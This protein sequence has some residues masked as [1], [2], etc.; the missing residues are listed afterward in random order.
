[1]PATCWAR[2]PSISVAAAG[3]CASGDAVYGNPNAGVLF[4][5]SCTVGLL[6]SVKP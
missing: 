3:V 6:C 5:T 1:M 4:H 2:P